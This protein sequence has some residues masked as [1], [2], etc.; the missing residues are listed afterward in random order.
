MPELPE[1]E[2]IVRDLRP[3][4]LG[5]RIVGVQTDWPKYFTFPKSAALA[6]IRVGARSAYFC[7]TE[8]KLV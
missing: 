6:R 4:L 2:R 7:P 1:V 5:R 3:Q 8:Q